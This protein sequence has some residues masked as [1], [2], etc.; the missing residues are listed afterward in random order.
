MR[1]IVDLSMPVTYRRDED[2]LHLVKRINESGRGL[3]PQPLDGVLGQIEGQSRLRS[4]P[5]GEWASSERRSFGIGAD[6]RP[7]AR[8]DILLDC[9]TSSIPPLEAV[10]RIAADQFL[11]DH[12]RTVPVHPM[13]YPRS[14]GRWR[15]SIDLACCCGNPRRQLR[16]GEG[17]GEAGAEGSR[18][19]PGPRTG[20][21]SPVREALT[22]RP[23]G[24]TG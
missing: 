5:P 7:I 24:C 4:Q 19:A 12:L 21:F 13:P 22:C 6:I 20:L 11:L 16:V 3:V 17:V 1:L 9:P 15:Y 14:P 8:T 2:L 23:A 10:E 18:P